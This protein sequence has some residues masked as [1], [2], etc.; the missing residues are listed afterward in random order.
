[1]KHVVKI[2]WNGQAGEWWNET[3]ISVIEVFGLPGDRFTWHPTVDFMEF[4]FTKEK[5]AELCRI[6]LSEKL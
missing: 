3:C 4:K 2:D 6:L 5:D 1:M